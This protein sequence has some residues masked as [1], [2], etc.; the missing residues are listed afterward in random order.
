M[1]LYGMTMY[2]HCVFMYDYPDW[3]FSVRFTQLWGK[4][5]D[6]TRKDGARPALFLVVVLLYVIFVFYVFLCSLYCLFCDVSC[7]CVYMCTEQ[8][9]PG[10][11]PNAVKYISCHILSYII[12]YII[13]NIIS[14]IICNI[15]SYIIYLLGL[16]I[17][18]GPDMHVWLTSRLHT[19]TGC[20][21]MFLP[22]HHTYIWGY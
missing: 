4:C 2:S 14:Y 6:K 10:G 7:I 21:L 1:Y 17:K 15:I 9:P 22:L 20:G 8:L 11:H 19:H 13:C 16:K 3:G 18:R 12:T 5:H